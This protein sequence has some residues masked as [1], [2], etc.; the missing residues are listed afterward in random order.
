LIEE[1][2]QLYLASVLA[3]AAARRAVPDAVST[4]T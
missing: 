4:I 2:G 3:M 1:V